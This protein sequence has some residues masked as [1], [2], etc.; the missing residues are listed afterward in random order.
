MTLTTLLLLLSWTGS[1]CDVT[2]SLP[3]VW[4]C[5][6]PMTTHN[7]AVGMILLRLLGAGCWSVWGYYHQQVTYLI[8]AGALIAFFVELILLGFFLRGSRKP[9]RTRQSAANS[10]QKYEGRAVTSFT[11]HVGT[12]EN[13]AAEL[14]YGLVNSPKAHSSVSFSLSGLISLHPNHSIS[15]NV[16]SGVENHGSSTINGG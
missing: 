5:R 2:S 8:L 10:E 15:S 4:K 13:R 14:L 16:F 6:H 9:I 1:I 11:P 7:L 12:H 3:Q